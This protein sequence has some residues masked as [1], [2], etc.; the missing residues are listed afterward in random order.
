M[1][2]RY[3]ALLNSNI[4]SVKVSHLLNLN[5]GSLKDSLLGRGNNYVNLSLGINPLNYKDTVVNVPTIPQGFGGRGCSWLWYKSSNSGREG[6]Y[7]A[8]TSQK[9]IPSIYIY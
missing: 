3:D 1:E 9:E 6:K 4:R 8:T 7:T 5:S 2:Q